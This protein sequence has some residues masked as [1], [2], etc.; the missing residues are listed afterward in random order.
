MFP[1]W[2]PVTVKSPEHARAGECGTVQSGPNEAGE[3]SVKF[4]A[5][6]LA[7]NILATDLQAL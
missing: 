7:V 5:D 1:V 4:D 6:G 2:T 3:V